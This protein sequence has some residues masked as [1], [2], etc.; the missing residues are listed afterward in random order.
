MIMVGLHHLLAARS[1]PKAVWAALVTGYAGAGFV[2][3]LYPPWMV[4]LVYAFT[5]M[6]VGVI[7]RDRTWQGVSRRQTR[8]EHGSRGKRG[9]GSGRLLSAGRV[10]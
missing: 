4:P 6:L 2:L 8:A 1:L 3:Q 5:A 10:A 9:A 7:I